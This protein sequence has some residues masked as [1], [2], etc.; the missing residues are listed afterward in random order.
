MLERRPL[1]VALGLFAASLLVCGSR[2]SVPDV[3]GDDEAAD[4]GV[5]WEMA[6]NG[7]W[8][9]P[10]FNGEMVP[11]KPPLFFWIAAGVSRLR[12]RVDEVSVREPSAVMAAITVAAVFLAGRH[13]VGASTAL[14]ASLI[15][16][17]SPMTLARAQL[18][19]VDMT[20]VACTTGAFF[21]AVFALAP[22]ARRWQRNVFWLLAALA[23]LVKAS[24]GLGLVIC[25]TLAV[26]IA[27]RKRLSHLATPEGIA[28]F[29]LVAF[30][31]YG[32][33]TWTLGRSFVAANLI[34]ENLKLFVGEAA[35]GRTASHGLR[36][37][38][39][40]PAISLIG[41]LVPWS[42]FAALDLRRWRAAR[43]AGAKLA[44]AWAAAGLG[45]FTAADAR[46]VYYVAP[47]V[48]P[49]ALF[50]ASVLNA[51][52]PAG[53]APRCRAALLSLGATG[54]GLL[55]LRVWA[56]ED[57]GGLSASDRLNLNA[58]AALWPAE[59]R[60]A[61]VLIGALAASAIVFLGLTWR[62]RPAW[63]LGALAISLGAQGVMQ[64]ALSAAVNARFSLKEFS[65]TVGRVKGAV[66]FLGPVIPQIVYHSRRHIHSVSVEDLPATRPLHLIT[67]EKRL[68]EARERLTSPVHVLVTGEG[69]LGEIDSARV[70]LLAVDEG[71]VSLP[72]RGSVDGSRP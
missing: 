42:L 24:A 51:E 47:L 72:E 59:S 12:G 62:P 21:A 13:L 6:E 66:Y 4:A 25:G 65:G 57:W 54:C 32:F 22:S 45:F 20:L 67:T 46:H 1:V 52:R 10:F 9:L 37:M 63:I 50:L 3:C 31:W 61:F 58:L 55:L 7:H 27:D 64:E 44:V 5:V 15:T 39:N 2:L 43:E 60:T 34:G 16:L 38:L 36:Q 68:A 30:G 17:S 11:E 35:R 19:R 23:V 53:A 41:A 48:P 70:L 14:L 8:L 33:A 69:R 49:L 28:L 29:G 56:A 40:T 71:S 26:A 18:G